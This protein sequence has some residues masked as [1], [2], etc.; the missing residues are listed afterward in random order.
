[1]PFNDIEMFKGFIETSF[2]DWKAGLCSVLFT[3][4]C[5]F[6]C[7][8]CHNGPIVEDPDMWSTIPMDYVIN[9][10]TEQKKWVERV[11]ICGGEP[12][13]HQDLPDV[14][15]ALKVLGLMIKLDTN[16]S[17]PAMIRSL[18]KEGLIDYVAMDVKGPL[19]G[20][21]RWCGTE[22][23]TEKVTD[24][25]SFLLKGSVPCEFRMTVVPR[26]HAEEDVYEVARY[27]GPAAAF[28][29]QEFRPEATVLDPDFAEIAPFP[30]DVMESIRKNVCRITASSAETRA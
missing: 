29:V 11:V 24:S 10:L 20:Y 21:S 9:K 8:F 5:N 7:P 23:D 4:G 30:A 3:G 22:V 27:L 13:I 26:L 2:V 25:I 17:N 6:R 14:L 12:T 28:T 19:D 1:M 15:R 18:A 16:G